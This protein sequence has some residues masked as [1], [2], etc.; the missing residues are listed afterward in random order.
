MRLEPLSQARN[1]SRVWKIK[2]RAALAHS[3]QTR[4][5]I[6]H[7]RTIGSR[8]WAAG[9][10]SSREREGGSKRVPR[11]LRGELQIA[12]IDPKAGADPERLHERSDTDNS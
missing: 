3:T 12:N 7:I 5:R 6:H 4:H 11:R 8:S 9:P 2:C 1:H 10:K